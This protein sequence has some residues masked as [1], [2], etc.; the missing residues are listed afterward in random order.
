[1]NTGNAAI[2]RLV[3]MYLEDR[4]KESDGTTT[5]AVKG[6][7]DRN[8]TYSSSSDILVVWNEKIGVGM[9]KIPFDVKDL[10]LA[11]AGKLKIEWAEREMP[12]LRLIGERFKKEK[13]LAG[14]RI[15]ACLHVTTETANLAM[16]LKAGGADVYLCASNPLSTQDEVAAA[17]VKE[18]GIPT[19]AI[20]GEDNA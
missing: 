17:L 9:K 5:F 19:F 8:F 13:P 12:V 11:D 20:K 4:D 1:M 6:D 18:S 15:S 3:P 16:V 14:V 10:S 7:G 2:S